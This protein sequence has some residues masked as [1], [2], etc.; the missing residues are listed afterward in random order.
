MKTASIAQICY[1]NGIPFLSIRRITDAAKRN[2]GKHFE[3]NHV[4][5]SGIA[6]NL[7]IGIIQELV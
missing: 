5:T 6:A 1:V 4:K 7:A 3:P 2:G